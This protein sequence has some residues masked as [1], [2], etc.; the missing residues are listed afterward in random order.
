[1]TT[2]SPVFFTT[3]TC[4]CHR[5][6]IIFLPKSSQPI[7]FHYLKSTRNGNFHQNCL[8]I[9]LCAYRR[10]GF[11]PEAMRITENGILWGDEKK[12]RLQK[13]VVLVKFNQ[14]PDNFNGGSGGGGDKRDDGTTARVL[15]NLALAVG[16][17]YLTMTGQLGWVLDTIVSLW[18]LAIIIPVVGLGAFLWWAG[19]DII[20]DSCP[21]CGNAFQVFK[22]TLNDEP[23]LCPYCAQP[24]SV[25]GNKFV[26]EP[27]NFSSKR[28]TP[29][30]QIFDDFSPWSREE[31]SA[32]SSVVDVEAEVKDAE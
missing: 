4:F 1:M 23:Q 28:S 12:L 7:K 5:P 9:E 3:S 30:G 32:S 26:K 27:I 31:K 25:E 13:R 2:L 19:R 20:Q 29:F 22:S 15:V 6:T 17:T 16:L 8:T 21:N 24:F 11:L 14:F 18:L 10:K